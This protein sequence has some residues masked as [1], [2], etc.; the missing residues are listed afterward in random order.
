MIELMEIKFEEN[1]K[2]IL[3]PREKTFRRSDISL[4]SFTFLPY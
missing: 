3:N 2:E 1:Q 4:H